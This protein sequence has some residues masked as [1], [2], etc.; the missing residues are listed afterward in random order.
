MWRNKKSLPEIANLLEVS[1]SVLHS[2]IYEL[3]KK[4]AV[5]SG[6]VGLQGSI[7]VREWGISLGLGSDVVT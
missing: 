3:I 5:I 7:P 2:Y 4:D 1:E 6:P